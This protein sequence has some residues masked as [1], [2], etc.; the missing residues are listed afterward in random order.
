[1]LV[2]HALLDFTDCF[3]ECDRGA[4]DS[5]PSYCYEGC[6]PESGDLLR[7]P[8]TRMSEEIARG[9]MQYLAADDSY[10]REGKM[11]GI[12][13]VEMPWGELRILKAFS[14]LL[15]GCSTVDG[16]VPPIPGR[17]RVAFE[18]ARTV[19]QLET[20]KQELILLN[21]LPQLSL[22]HI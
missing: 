11:Y 14:G 8:R 12:L 15:N 13:L 17:S 10:A 7:L 2:L 16:W 19:A 18:E 4:I 5:G 1:M 20:M 3:T 6:C 9:L 21:Q 22:I